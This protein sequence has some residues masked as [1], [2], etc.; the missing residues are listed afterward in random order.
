MYMVNAFD[1]VCHSFVYEVL[2]RFQFDEHVIQW[3]HAYIG[4]PWI[5]TFINGKPMSFF[6]ENEDQ[7]KVSAEINATTRAILREDGLRP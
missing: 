7:G 6:K 4:S 3:I 2:Q 5:A 1:R